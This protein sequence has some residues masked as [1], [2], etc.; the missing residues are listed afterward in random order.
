MLLANLA[1]AAL[2][3]VARA[4][5]ESRLVERIAFRRDAG[6][7]VA[8]DQICFIHVGKTGGATFRA[9]LGLGNP[10]KDARNVSAI[11]AGRWNEFHTDEK[12]W[13]SLEWEERCDFFV[14]WVRHPV[15]RL[16]SAFEL[17]L[18]HI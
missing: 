18:I 4:G 13:L 5:V 11:R 2:A 16:V 17:S 8:A 15:S 9:A 6:D 3:A 12:R 14:T 7:L 1:L 10:G